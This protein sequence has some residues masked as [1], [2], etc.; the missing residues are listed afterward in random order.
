VPTLTKKQ[1]EVLNFIKDFVSR[2]GYA[3]SY[4]EIAHGLGL[5]SQSTIHVH[6]E[7][8]RSKGFLTKKWNAN[9]SIDL[10]E[11]SS[12][13]RFLVEAPLAGR[14]VAGEPLEAI[15]DIQTIGLP[16][17]MVGKH[18]TYVLQ[19]KGDSMIEDHVLDGDYVIVEK[20]QLIQDGDMVVALIKGS[21]A[22]LKRFY[23]EQRRIRLQPSNPRYEA[24]VYDEQEVNIQ[25]VVIGILRKLAGH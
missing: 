7:N 23:K 24:L 14:I 4:E 1:R 12:H 25:G 15:E 19:V 3:P 8:L 11:H 5:S 18:E 2:N 22:T 13:S 17:E 20:R 21:E 10:A 16:S 9:R 6:I